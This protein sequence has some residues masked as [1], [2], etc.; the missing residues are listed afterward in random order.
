MKI[1]HL[2]RLAVGVVLLAIVVAQIDSGSIGNG[3]ISGP[4]SN[5]YIVNGEWINF[6]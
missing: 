5:L 3:I 6:C 1:K 4:V 2:V